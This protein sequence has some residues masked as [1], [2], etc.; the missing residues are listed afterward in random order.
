MGKDCIYNFQLL[1]DLYNIIS[2]KYL[3]KFMIILPQFALSKFSLPWNT[4]YVLATVRVRFLGML[5]NHAP[6]ETPTQTQSSYFHFK[7]KFKRKWNEANH[8]HRC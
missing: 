2:Y 8:K 4:A 1:K 5:T 7:M 6:I 3:L